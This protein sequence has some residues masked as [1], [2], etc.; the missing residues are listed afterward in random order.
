MSPNC[1]AAWFHRT[2]TAKLWT[3]CRLKNMQTG[4]GGVH[5]L[6]LQSQQGSSSCLNETYLPEITCIICYSFYD[7]HVLNMSSIRLTSILEPQNFTLSQGSYIHLN[8]YLIFYHE[9]PYLEYISKLGLVILF[10]NMFYYIC[11]QSL[12]IQI[13]M[14]IQ[15]MCRPCLL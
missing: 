15:K 12:N 3:D 11:M 9:L 7:S 8:C 2:L 6:A 14:K 1:V 5:F 13:T 4:S 10:R